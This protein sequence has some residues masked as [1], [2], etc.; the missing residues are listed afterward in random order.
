MALI[1][2]LQKKSIIHVLN[3]YSS[4]CVLIRLLVC[5]CGSI[6]TELTS[7]INTV[8]H[9]HLHRKRLVEEPLPVNIACD[10]LFIRATNRDRNTHMCAYTRRQFSYCLVD[11]PSCTLPKN[12]MRWKLICRIGGNGIIWRSCHVQLTDTRTH[13]II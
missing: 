6:L 3:K 9:P 13:D 5:G 1:V 7:S 8:P 11:I 4:T 12:R 10:S 2:G